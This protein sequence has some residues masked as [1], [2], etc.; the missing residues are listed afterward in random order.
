[1]SHIIVVNTKGNKV[2]VYPENLKGIN[3]DYF[4]KKFS[5]HFAFPEDVYN[6]CLEAN[7][8]APKPEVKKAEKKKSKE[9]DGKEA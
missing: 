3:K 8:P 4:L 1:M 6:L 2:K 7:K 9:A 5:K